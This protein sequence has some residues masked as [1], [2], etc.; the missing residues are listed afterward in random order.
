MSKSFTLTLL[1]G[2]AAVLVLSGS[3]YVTD[4]RQQ[5]EVERIQESRR[6]A[7][8][9]SARVDELL[10]EQSASAELARDAYARWN[11]RYKYIPTELT[12]ADMLEYL[13][14]LTRRGFEQFD[15]DL[16]GQ[17]T[18]PDF[19]TYTFAIKGI[20]TYPA[21]YDLVWHLENNREFYR[22][23]DLKIEHATLNKT[24][25]RTQEQR[26]IDV[27][28]FECTLD[29]YFAGIEGI[30]APE[31]SLKP[32]P[33]GLLT[34]HRPAVDLFR[35]LVRTDVA[36]ND[37]LLPD[38]QNMKLVAIIGLEAVFDTSQGRLILSQGDT[39]YL[40]YVEAVDPMAAVV[41]I[42]VNRG[43]RTERLFYRIG[44]EEPTRQWVPNGGATAFP[45]QPPAPAPPPGPNQ[46]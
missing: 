15:M 33:L 39:V 7:A 40:G 24:N 32:I 29:A 30:S 4:V 20:A 38:F 14:G 17:T 18:T 3:Y 26:Q 42:V 8:L 12:T 9:L 37:R 21:L 6:A 1:L 44:Q 41:R 43:D 45:A 19:S 36:P 46:Q 11:A 5:G 31:D 10:V 22:I 25:P 27:V 28:T 16:V 2:L 13:E 23:N 35:P 34:A